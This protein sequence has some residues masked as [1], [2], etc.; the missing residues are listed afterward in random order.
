MPRAWLI[1][2]AGGM[3]GTALQRVLVAR[4][5]RLEAPPEGS[6]DITD[7][8]VVA[9]VVHGFAAGLEPGTEG[10]LVN[11]AAYTDVER[12]EDEPEV[13]QLVNG[14]APRL[15]AE[16]ARDAGLR[17]VHVSTD[18]VFDGTKS[19]AYTEEDAPNPLSVYGRSKLDGE[20]GVLEADSDA[21]VARAAWA[22]GP[23]GVNFPVK[24]L[25]AARTRPALKVV[26]DE[27]GSPTYTLDLA[28]GIVGLVEAGASGLYNL[29]GSGACSRFELA[30]E[31]LRL[32]GVD[33]P[34]EPVTSDAFPTRA[35][36]PANSVLDCAKAARSGVT[37][38]DWHDSLAD[39]VLGDLG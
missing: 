1:A 9:R 10:V 27:V 28:A 30:A 14:R 35:A 3:L 21:L 37:M 7:E 15:L 18:F 22:F 4:G 6:F 36:R 16:V 26:T 33:T 29:V 17:F 12:A 19:G 13:A 34:L 32:A 25:A 5:E 38:R 31:T 11:A 23:A 24:I 2:G 8:G 20:R 39:F